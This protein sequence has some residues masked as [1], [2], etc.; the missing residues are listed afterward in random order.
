MKKWQTDGEKNTIN[1]DGHCVQGQPAPV[2]SKLGTFNGNHLHSPFLHQISVC[3]NYYTGMAHF[4]ATFLIFLQHNTPQTGTGL[5]Q[6]MY[7]RTGKSD[8]FHGHFLLLR[9]QLCISKAE[10]PCSKH[11]D[12]DK[13][14]VFLR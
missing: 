10:M 2:F 11:L 8:N 9:L 13:V 12:S 4:D 1:S 3:A 6:M 7:L 14:R 5:L